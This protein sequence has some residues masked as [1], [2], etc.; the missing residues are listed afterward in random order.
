MIRPARATPALSLAAAAALLA[1]ALLLPGSDA[2]QAQNAAPTVT[3]ARVSSTPA[4]GDT[5]L[6]GE[7]IRVTL[8]FSETV[9]VTGTPRLKIDMDPAEWGEKWA[10]YESGGGTASLTFAH[11]VVEPNY[12]TQGIA[13]PANTLELNGG[14]IRSASSETDA[15][16]AH[17]ELA[18]DAG[19]K[20]NWQRSAAAPAVSGVEVS[21]TPAS[22]DTYLL[23]ETIRVTLAFSETVNVTGSPRLTIDMDPAAWGEKWASYESGGGTASLTFT[24][25]VVEPNYSTQ[26]IAVLANTLELNGGAIRSASSETDAALAHTELAHDAMHRV[27]WQRT[28][29]NRAPVVNTGTRNYETFTGEVNAPRGVLVSKSFHRIFSD[30]DGDQLS[31]AVSITGGLAELVETLAIGTHG[32]SDTIAAKSPFPL[33]AV[34]RVFLQPDADDDWDAIVPALPDLPVV[35]VTLTATDPDGLSASVQ[36]DFLIHWER[37]PDCTLAPPERVSAL[38]VARAAVALW[39]A[40]SGEDACE[41]I[42]YS[43]SAR[44]AEGGPWTSGVAAAAAT[45]H[46]LEELTPGLVEYEVLAV[47]PEGTSP[48]PTALPQIAVPEACNITL[49]VEADVDRGISGTWKNVAGTPT[50]CVFGPEIEYLF[51]ESSHDHFRNYGRF[52]NH[53]QTAPTQDSFIGYGLKPGITYDF[54]IVAVDAAGR[55]NESNV[56]SATV[57]YDA[58]AADVHSPTNVRVVAINDSSASVTWSAPASFSAGRTLSKYVVEWKTGAAAATTAEVASGITN[59]RIT[60]L[61]DGSVYT[62]RVAAR[63]TDAANT[64]LD[65]WSAPA[66]PFTAWSEPTKIWAIS[67]TPTVLGGRLFVHAQRNKPIGAT[68]CPYNDGTPATYNC[69]AGTLAGTNIDGDPSVTIKNTDADGMTVTR[70]GPYS[71]SVGGPHSVPVYASGGNGTLVV[72]WEALIRNDHVGAHDAWIVQRRKQNTDGTWPT[73]NDSNNATKSTTDLTH[74]FT[75]LANGIWQVLVH[76]RSDGDD[77]DPM[78]TDTARL[79]FDSETLTV[80]LAAGNTA[81]PGRVTGGTVTPGV[82]SLIVEWEPPAGGGSAV[83]AYQVQYRLGG[84]DYSLGVRTGGGEYTEGPVIY[85]RSVRRLCEDT[86][87]AGGTVTGV[88]CENPRRYE[89]P[90]LIG[91]EQ[92]DVSVR[93]I[94]ANGAGEWTGVGGFNMPNGFPPVLESA[95]VNGTALTLTFTQN[96]DTDSEPAADAFTVN[97]A[98]TDQTPTD[99][100][101]SGKT[102]TLT[103]GTAVTSG[104][105]VTVSYTRPDS[106]PLQHNDAQAPGFSGEMVTN[107]TS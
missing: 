92:Y 88:V 23:G 21:S 2:A 58:D 44:S 90:G 42:G 1:L 8:T 52:D 45:S 26:G 37:G 103:L 64:I 97:V 22:G 91:G 95:A 51:K 70:S 78:T 53:R 17:T 98:G 56:A 35:T 81:V 6:L 32:R 107:N 96:L 4:S 84:F 57:V 54:K 5:Y 39:Q 86:K 76:A 72:V 67:G 93:A 75:G 24:H 10:G 65:S 104:Q 15:A 31:Y 18:H 46:V 41:P 89:I 55:K 77:G 47:Y 94:N 106:N 34:L 61:T 30:P 48:R 50:G 28:E 99:V 16:L 80:T 12:S 3:G 7:T 87:D 43:V 29:P 82:G 79:G 38:G 74:T 20:V 49:T 11:T 68:V 66:A 9:D 105:T 27:D 25:T 13:V 33:D 40:P 60:G 100:A 102:V 73:W 19:H 63:T 59:H 36:G 62:V 14:A 83:H 85:P 71:G 69:P 101:I